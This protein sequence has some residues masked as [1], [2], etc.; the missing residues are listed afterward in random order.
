[1]PESPYEELI[2]K[3]KEFTRTSQWAHAV[4]EL[5]RAI[6]LAPEQPEAH[7]QLAVALQRSGDWDTAL[8]ELEEAN[9]TIFNEPTLLLKLAETQ[10][11]LGRDDEAIKAYLALAQVYFRE[12]DIKMATD[13]LEKAARIAPLNR[14]LQERLARARAKFNTEQPP[15]IKEEQTPIAPEEPAEEI[16]VEEASPLEPGTPKPE[17]ATTAPQAEFDEK[18]GVGETF[19]N[20][21]GTFRQFETLAENL[22][23]QDRP[24]EAISYFMEAARL[25]LNDGLLDGAIDEGLHRLNLFPDYLP[26]HVL[27][28]KVYM[29]KG[30]QNLARE[31]F[32]LLARL[33]V[34]RDE[35]D[36]ALQVLNESLD[37]FPNDSELSGFLKQLA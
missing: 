21:V 33:Y 6:Q 10:D 14:D 28:A 13:A 19:D 2:K 1:M 17:V 35:R 22:L 27:L 25:C 31:K 34:L 26:V 12:H 36:K 20:E 3:G 30:L 4:R 7:V 15:Q 29:I 8:F 18:V 24:T 23:A 11:Y 9:K 32:A 37:F 16:I 5:K